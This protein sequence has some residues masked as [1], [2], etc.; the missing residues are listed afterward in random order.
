MLII[1]GA[2]LAFIAS[3]VAR[4]SRLA[5]R[6]AQLSLCSDATTD[7]Y[8]DDMTNMTDKNSTTGLRMRKGD[9][10]EACEN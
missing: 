7:N 10:G 6:P 5:Q 8:R 1:S 9:Q 2:A 4:K 3:L